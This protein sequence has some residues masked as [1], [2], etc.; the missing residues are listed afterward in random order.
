MQCLPMDWVPTGQECPCPGQNAED[1]VGAPDVVVSTKPNSQIAT[2]AG[3][4][5]LSSTNYVLQVF[6]APDR[7]LGA[8]ESTNYQLLLS[9]PRP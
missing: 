8:L 3:G 1:S 2:T 7:P 6:V 9:A 5:T 4:A